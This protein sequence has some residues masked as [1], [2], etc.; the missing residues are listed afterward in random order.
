M[1]CSIWNPSPFH[2]DSTW[3]PYGLFHMESME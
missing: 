1:D 3:I 2:M